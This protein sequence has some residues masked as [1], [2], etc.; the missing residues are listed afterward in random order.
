MQVAAGVSAG[1]GL[2]FPQPRQI[3]RRARAAGLSAVRR[4]PRVSHVPRG[5]AVSQH[6]SLSP[7]ATARPARHRDLAE[8]VPSTRRKLVPRLVETAR[9]YAFVGPALL[10]LL[11]FNLVAVAYAG[12]L[13]LFDARIISNMWQP[14]TWVGLGNYPDIATNPDFQSA[15]ANT[16]WYVLGVVPPAIF[17]SLLVASLLNRPIR[18]RDAYRVAYFL[19]YVTSTVAAGL[20]WEWVFQPRVGIANVLF[21]ALGFPIQRWIEEPRGVVT[22]VGGYFGL[23][24]PTWLAGPS[25]ALVC[26]A[27]IQVWHALGFDTVIMLAGLTAIPNEQYEAARIDG[28]GPWALFRHITIPLLSPTLFFLLITSVIRAFQAFNWFYVVYHGTVPPDVKVITIYLYESGFKVYRTGY[29]SAVG[30][31]LF[32]IILALTL[33]QMY[34]LRS[35]VHYE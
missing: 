11:T 7:A 1:W 17:L 26:I 34:G 8:P 27:V 28:A 19:P 18:G 31:V 13:S 23:G 20:V 29:A 3:G 35:R 2:K 6:S 9:G 16:V 5:I 21:T 10:I 22:L 33:A 24:V 14:G 32:A 4:V 25:L 15:L 12:F 30:F